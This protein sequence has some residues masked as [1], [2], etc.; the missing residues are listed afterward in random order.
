[1]KIINYLA[2]FGADH[3]LQF[4]TD[5]IE[6]DTNQ[7]CDFELQSI[8]YHTKPYPQGIFSE[9]EINLLTEICQNFLR[10]LAKD[11]HNPT[12][13]NLNKILSCIMS[14]D[15]ATKEIG[16]DLQENLDYFTDFID[17]ETERNKLAEDLITSW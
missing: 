10:L 6:F 8:P 15:Y 11:P 13:I 7:P 16:F 9:R 5:R 14:Q 12:L 17:N 4:I 2:K 1:M 3:N